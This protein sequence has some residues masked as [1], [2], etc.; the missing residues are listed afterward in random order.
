MTIHHP[1]ITNHHP[2]TT[3][4]FLADTLLFA[5]LSFHERQRIADDFQRQSYSAG[6][7]IFH[8][9]DPGRVLYLIHSGQ[10]RIF[11]NGI[12]GTETSVIICG[13]PG[14]IFGELAII[15]GLPRSATAAAVTPAIVYTMQR[16]QFRQH[17]RRT[18]QLALNFMQ[19]LASRVRYNTGQLD[20]LASLTV[21]RRL[22]RKLLELA[23]DYGQVEDDGVRID[24]PL[25]QS[26]LASLVVA[27][28]ESINKVLRQFRHQGLI[29]THNRHIIIHD[30]GALRTIVAGS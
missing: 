19:T 25:T 11:V 14:D 6:E 17:M 23:Q 24:T 29:T 15:D 20:S 1:L 26:N 9:G 16:E 2:L 18:P 12:E 3:M 21:S 27:T 10:V 30:A 8:Q 4:N 28:R 22:A 13:R 5:K 7:T